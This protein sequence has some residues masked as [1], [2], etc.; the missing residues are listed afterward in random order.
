MFMVY[1][2]TKECASVYLATLMLF[3]HK[4]IMGNQNSTKN[5][6]TYLQA[7]LLEFQH[8]KCIYVYLSKMM[9]YEHIGHNS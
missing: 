7:V 6:T 5:A 8:P 3:I 4:V 9:K 1:V 2:L